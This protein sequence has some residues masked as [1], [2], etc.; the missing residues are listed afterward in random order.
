MNK[1]DLDIL[2]N[3]YYHGETTLDE[4]QQLR[5]ALGG[6]DADALLMQALDQMEDE[7]EVP[8]DL[9]A[10][11]SSKIDE[12]EAQENHQAK[13]IRKAK[14]APLFRKR[15]AW[16]AAA[17]VAVIAAVGLWM[18]R[19]G[20]PQMQVP[21][22][23]QHKTIAKTIDEPAQAPSAKIEEP[24]QAPSAKIEET[25]HVHNHDHEIQPRARQASSYKGNVEHLAQATNSTQGQ[26]AGLSS[27]DEEIAI[28]A[29]E[30]FSTVLNKGMD[31]LNDASEKIND[32]NNTIQQHL[33]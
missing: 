14:V 22:P 16:A 25:D 13:K 2:L 30:K 21:A 24:A 19:G 20:T 23:K 1:N 4:E 12:W 6:D 33:I 7:V 17:S 8:A 10:S 9:E 18:M 5:G 3:K 26:D 29:L 31:Q 11:L 15:T 28:A 27:S 32:I